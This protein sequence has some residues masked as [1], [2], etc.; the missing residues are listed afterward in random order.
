MIVFTY[1]GPD[2]DTRQFAE[3]AEEAAPWGDVEFVQLPDG[4]CNGRVRGQGLDVGGRRVAQADRLAGQS[5][6]ASAGAGVRESV[7]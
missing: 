2:G 5:M 1:L 6:S 7:L 4:V 3:Q